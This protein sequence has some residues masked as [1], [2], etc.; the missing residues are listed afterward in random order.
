MAGIGFAQFPSF[1]CFHGC[2]S[3]LHIC[4][5]VTGGEGVTTLLCGMG[6]MPSIATVGGTPR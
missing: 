6:S 5:G 4:R 1:C 3:F 2:A